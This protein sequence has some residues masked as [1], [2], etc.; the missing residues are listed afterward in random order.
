MQVINYSVYNTVKHLF[1]ILGNV[2]KD[3]FSLCSTQDQ[4]FF[5]SSPKV[6]LS[7][8]GVNIVSNLL[9]E[10]YFNIFTIKQK[11]KRE[12]PT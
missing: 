9:S 11:G 7:R 10:F 8:V 5:K 3:V 2:F 4:A 12:T 1:Y 6:Q